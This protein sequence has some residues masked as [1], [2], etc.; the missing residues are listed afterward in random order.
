MEFV[1]MAA[2]TVIDHSEIGAGGTAYWE[3]TSIPT[4]GT[5]DH[6][7]IKA[8]LLGEKDVWYDSPSITVNGITSSVYSNTA[9]YSRAVTGAPNVTREGARGNLVNCFWPGA[10]PDLS[11]TT[12]FGSLEIW[13]PHYANSTN[14][15]PFV[16]K[17][18]AAQ[19]SVGAGEWTNCILAGLYAQTTAISSI[20]IA[21]GH[22]T[23]LARY[24]TITLYGIK[25]V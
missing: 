11:N 4:D 22:G 19:A 5:Y 18:V 1:L 10:R 23:D 17:A 8:S 13:I 16:V 2:V 20:K 24:S 12:T 14:Y 7:L 6:L 15:K 9:M 25:G 21:S 3:E